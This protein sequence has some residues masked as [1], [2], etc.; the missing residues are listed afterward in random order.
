MKENM[1]EISFERS[2]NHNYMILRKC[3]YFGSCDI[4]RDYRTRML[5]ENRIPGLLPVTHRLVN[6]ES[7]YYYEI[8][9]LQSLDRLY[10]KTE[11]RYD[12]LLS[13][14]SGCV[15]LF[16]GLEEYLLD[17]AQ[18]IMEP[19]M[20]Y[21]NVERMEPYFVC[22]PDYEG[23]VR[24]SFMEFIDELLT[25]IDHTDECAVMLGYQIY[26]YTR[27]PNYV[28]SGIGNIMGYVTGELVHR[29]KAV[30]TNLAAVEEDCR[31]NQA[32]CAVYADDEES[33]VEE[34]PYDARRNAGKI[35]DLAGGIFCSLV[36]LCSGAIILGARTIHA[37]EPGRNSELY[38]FGAMA[39]ALVAAVLFFYCHAKK[40]RQNMETEQDDGDEDIM[41]YTDA[42]G[43]DD[44]QGA[45][46]KKPQE[47][48]P[49]NVQLFKSYQQDYCAQ[50]H[51]G[52]TE[53]LGDGVVEERLLCGRI[54][55]KE[56][57]ISLD[58]LPMTVGK[59]ANMSDLVINDTA[60]SKMHARFEEHDGRVYV[61]DL[62]STNGTARNGVLLGVNQSVA[63]EPG[64][65]L[66]FGRT[67]FTYC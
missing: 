45:F 12:G 8:N 64:D 36:A 58:R 11:I 50:S 4:S 13:L 63:L 35:T 38:L 32:D 65:R 52:E 41:Y 17:G 46:C 43:G 15:K 59:L 42:G 23:D 40:R 57:S 48:Q 20:I 21:L 25:R 37:F 9:S 62:N 10:N 30:A 60:V 3:S 55:G 56:V 29:Q 19:A 6:G 33:D 51:Y 14:L 24:L 16:E 47:V 2:M 1:P 28:I 44:L 7:C 39:M 66:R 49:D 34:S 31:E 67:Y 54:N 61:C 27:N 18:I 53:Y 26:R 22:Y 5:L